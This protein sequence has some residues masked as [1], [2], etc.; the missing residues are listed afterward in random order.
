MTDL[1]AIVKAGSG[2]ILWAGLAPAHVAEGKAV[3]HAVN[4]GNVNLLSGA[5]LGRHLIERGA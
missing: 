1:F 2:E 3:I 5:D 4:S